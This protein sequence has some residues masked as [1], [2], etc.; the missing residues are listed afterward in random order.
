M[1]EQSTVMV[2]K[3]SKSSDYELNNAE[4]VIQ[5]RSASD[6]LLEDYLLFSQVS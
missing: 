2:K 6:A 1:N 5:K 4:F 3:I